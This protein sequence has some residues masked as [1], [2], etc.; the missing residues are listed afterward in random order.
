MCE[1]FWTLPRSLS[2]VR[3]RIVAPDD[4]VFTI[5]SCFAREIRV[6]LEGLGVRVTPDYADVA[7]NLQRSR[8]DDLPKDPR[9]NHDNSFTILQEFER[10]L[11]LWT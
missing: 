6:A 2:L 3:S 9:L 10:H 11:G 4:M 7:V 8:I 5:G 1:R